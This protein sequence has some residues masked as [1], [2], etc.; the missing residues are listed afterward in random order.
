VLH[1]QFNITYDP[2]IRRLLCNG[3]VLNLAANT[4]IFNTN[5][6]TLAAYNNCGFLEAALPSEKELDAW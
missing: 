3:H 5:D 6:E 2:H 4:F 1:G